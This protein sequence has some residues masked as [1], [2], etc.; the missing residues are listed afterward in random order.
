MW[1]SFVWGGYDGAHLTRAG[2]HAVVFTSGAA[3]R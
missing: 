1:G 2:N 3:T